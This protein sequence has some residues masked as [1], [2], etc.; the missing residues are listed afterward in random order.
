MSPLITLLLALGVGW[1]G[2]APCDRPV[3]AEEGLIGTW[4][5]I[6]LEQNGEPVTLENAQDTRLVFT[7]KTYAI[8]KGKDTL[9]RGAYHVEAGPGLASIDLR[10]ENGPDKGRTLKGVYQIEGGALLMCI[11][12][13]SAPRPTALAATSGTNHLLFTYKKVPR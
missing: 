2:G 3:S 8:R 10:P 6:A 7:A 5:A 13:P 4:K 1:V 9:E 11:G 12:T